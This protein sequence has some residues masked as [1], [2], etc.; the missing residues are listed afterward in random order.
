MELGMV[1]NILNVS[2][3]YYRW[4]TA[5]EIFKFPLSVLKYTDFIAVNA[6]GSKSK[7]LGYFKSI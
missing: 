1:G 7:R 2:K 5:L 3:T 4:A 6:E